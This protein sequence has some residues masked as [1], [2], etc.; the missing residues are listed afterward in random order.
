MFLTRISIA[1]PVFTTMMMVAVVAFGLIGWR[2][3]PIDRF[4]AIDYP[5][6]AVMT[7]FSG[8]SPE[9]VESDVTRLIEDELSTLA[10]IDRITSTSAQGHSSVIALFTLETRSAT[11]VQD[12]RDSVAA[13]TPDL[14]SGA[15]A[16][17]VV[18]F[19]PTDDPVVTL[20]LSSANLGPGGLSRLAEDEIVPRLTAIPGVGTASLVGAVKDQI[21]V[22]PDPDLLR[23]HGLGVAD[24]ADA[25]RRDNLRVPGGAL[26]SGAQTLS[27]QMNA[28]VTSAED[29]GDLVIATQGAG[30]IRL[31]DLA[32]VTRG[33]SDPESLAFHN[34]QPALAIEVV[35]A[36][37]ANTVAVAHAVAALVSELNGGELPADARL[38][39]LTN[40]ATAIED[41]YETVRSTLFEGAV[42]AVVIVFFFLNSW[43]STV[44]TALTLPIAFLG[45]LA[46]IGMLGFTLNMLTM[47]ALTLSVGILIDDA[48]VVRE[49]ITRHLHMGKDHH[50]AAL[51]GTAEIGLAVVATT[52]ALCAVFLPL[53][54]MDG[55]VG[56][57]FVQFGITVTVA[58][59]ISLFVSFTLDPMLSSVWHDPAS[60]PG[61]RRGVFGRA[62]ARFGDGFDRL[63][64]RYSRLLAI[65]LRWRKTTVALALAC[66]IASLSLF[67]LLGFEFLPAGDEG[68]ISVEVKT[69][70]GS[71]RDYTALKTGQIAAIVADMPEV[72]GIYTAVA[73]GSGS[74]DNAARME[75]TLVPLAGR[76]ASADE[77]VVRMRA[78]LAQIPGVDL[79]I[80]SVG[81]AGGGGAPIEMSVR[82]RMAT[83]W[84]GRRGISR[85]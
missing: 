68:R 32:S 41:N 71:S 42:L 23:A 84:R 47:L 59:L 81:G 80:V 79:G 6:V 58:V 54:F 33:T 24:L 55:I 70:T 72:A 14:P 66:L 25:L 37:G 57:F 3:I 30:Q 1:Q 40:E 50:R 28:E 53:A 62:V 10:G 49:N 75:I 18:R 26:N 35:R 34:G 15:D 51:D 46:V 27:V 85:R 39:I 29:L 48:I 17:Q 7:P 67:P 64:E 63:G 76:T 73:A 21:T 11:A 83:I 52:L 2:S 9:T 69:A 4:P 65:C 12:V 78:A 77:M 31:R 16:P 44:I 38:D 20:A 74:G 82:G 56:R 13:I 19:N 60:Q 61:T 43:R 22:A 8:A 36:D 5:V 45:T